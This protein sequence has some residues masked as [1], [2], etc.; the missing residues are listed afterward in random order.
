MI[1]SSTTASVRPGDYKLTLSSPT[2]TATVPFRINPPL[3]ANDRLPGFAS[4]DVVYLLMP[5]R[6][7]NGDTTNDDPEISKGLYDRTN[8][9]GYHGGDLQGVIDHLPYLKDLGVTAIWMTHVML[10]AFGCRISQAIDQQ[11]PS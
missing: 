1:V 2:G 7:A 9:R 5:A 3:K 4:D 10:P 6:F 11:R 8:P